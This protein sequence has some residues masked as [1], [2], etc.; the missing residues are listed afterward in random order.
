M[1]DKKSYLQNLDDQLREWDVEIDKLKAAAGR[2]NAE[3]EME[4]L[5]Q[6]APIRFFFQ[7]MNSG[8][9]RKGRA[10]QVET[11]AGRKNSL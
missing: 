7:P 1:E 4:L 5:N 11:T 3:T 8:P 6:I 9:R 2:D 10:G